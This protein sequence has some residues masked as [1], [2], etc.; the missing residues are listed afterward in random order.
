MKYI[1]ED[2]VIKMSALR[3]M[4]SIPTSLVIVTDM[5]SKEREAGL[6]IWTEQARYGGGVRQAYFALDTGESLGDHL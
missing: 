3:K 5:D 2:R 4:P 6:C 1:H